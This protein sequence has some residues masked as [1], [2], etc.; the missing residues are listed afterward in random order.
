MSPEFEAFFQENRRQEH[1]RAEF[2]ANAIEQEVRLLSE[3]EPDLIR[4]IDKVLKTELPYDVKYSHCRAT[5][6]AIHAR[7]RAWNAEHLH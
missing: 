5:L 3:V 2:F 1:E 6:D 4:D 7:T